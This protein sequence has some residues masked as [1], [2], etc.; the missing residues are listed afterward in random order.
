M[1]QNDNAAVYWLILVTSI[2]SV[3]SALLYLFQRCCGNC[4][5]NIANVCFQIFANSLEVREETLYQVT[6]LLTLPRIFHQLEL[7]TFKVIWNHDA[8]AQTGDFVQYGWLRLP[9][10]SYVLA[11]LAVCGVTHFVYIAFNLKTVEIVGPVPAIHALI[12]LSNLAATSALEEAQLESGP[13]IL[14][15]FFAAA[16]SYINK[17]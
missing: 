9:T 7:Q 14:F 1:A 11:F 15:V 3:T 16:R 4:S 10:K 17:T 2:S 12:N 13:G 6:N 8:N 5:G